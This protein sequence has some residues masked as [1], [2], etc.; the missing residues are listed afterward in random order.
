VIV[1]LSLSAGGH[2]RKRRTSNS[3][4]PPG[5]IL[6]CDRVKMSRIQG[7]KVFISQRLTTSVDDILDHLERTILEYEEETERRHRD[8]LDVVLTAEMKQHRAGLSSFC[9]FKRD[10]WA[11]VD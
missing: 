7:L 2:V 8:F 9:D 6:S 4:N 3:G 11:N 10:R 5:L 1:W